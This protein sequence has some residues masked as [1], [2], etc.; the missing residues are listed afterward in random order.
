MV[1]ASVEKFTHTKFN[2]HPLPIRSEIP[3]SCLGKK[4]FINTNQID[5]QNLR[6]K[7]FGHI[8]AKIALI[9]A[10]LWSTSTKY[11]LFSLTSIQTTG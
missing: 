9:L 6:H 1:C 3:V 4:W 7:I 2:G 11:F 8:G 5:T 10:I